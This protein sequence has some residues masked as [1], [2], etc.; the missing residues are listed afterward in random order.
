[1]LVEI[2]ADGAN[3][4]V[5]MVD[6]TSMWHLWLALRRA[7]PRVWAACLVPTG[8]RIVATL[9]E[10]R[11]EQTVRSRLARLLAWHSRRAG[12]RRLWSPVPRAVV[13]P[14]RS[15]LARWVREVHLR[16]C[17][18]GLVAD[19]LAWPWSTYRGL[20]GAELDPWVSDSWLASELDWPEGDFRQRLHDYTSTGP[21]ANEAGTPLPVA[22][23]PSVVSSVPL[24]LVVRAAFSAAPWQSATARRRL[25]ASLAQ[26]Q[27]WASSSVVARAL[28]LSPQSVRRLVRGT[29][30]R[31]LAAGALCL[32]DERLL[33]DRATARALVSAHGGANSLDAVAGAPE[34]PA[35]PAC[36]AR[37]PRLICLES[38]SNASAR[39]S[40]EGGT[41]SSAWSA[42]RCA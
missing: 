42:T 13:I 18:D 31:W 26:H 39:S 38:S 12:R 32:G 30:P 8:V 25:A 27:G 36:R 21:D 9:V 11:F 5:P 10:P 23:A 15:Q 4:C 14:M 28:E 17:R 20:F 41:P 16:P 40:T 22:A 6:R 19:P 24:E 29:D 7:F 37:A 34:C 35:Q 2:I 33:F 1:M 3:G